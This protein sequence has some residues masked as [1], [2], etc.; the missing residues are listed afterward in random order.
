[1][2]K[3][4]KSGYSLIEAVIAVSILAI[5]ISTGLT[6]ILTASDTEETNND[7]LVGNMLAIEGAERVKNIYYTNILK[8]GSE[9]IAECGFVDTL[10]TTD[11]SQCT[12]NQIAD[13]TYVIEPSGA[14]IN[15]WQLRYIG[16][17]T[18]DED[19]LIDGDS[20]DSRFTLY[21]VEEFSNLGE[22]ESI[23]YYK[24]Y[25]GV[26]PDNYRST[27]FH[28]EILI[29]KTANLVQAV[30]RVG[31]IREDGNIRT[32]DVDITLPLSL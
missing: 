17:P 4:L 30:S 31:W 22:T 7:F 15:S 25:N 32:L 5:M 27:E 19:F 11:V 23:N 8:F 21:T 2:I 18:G 6:I 24:P 13:G 3:N 16:L 20:L 1:M 9:N 29:N 28:R 14:S 12:A 10:A 26:P